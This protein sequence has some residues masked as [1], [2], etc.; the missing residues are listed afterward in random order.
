MP[1]AKIADPGAA[2]AFGSALAYCCLNVGVR[3][4]ID[5]LSVAGILVVRGL[6]GVIVTVMAARAFKKR[7]FGGNKKLLLLIGL[8]GSLSTICT[9]TAIAR[10]PLYQ[11]LVLL[12]LYPALSVVFAYFINSSSISLRDGALAALAFCGC[13]VLIWPDSSAGLALDPGHFIGLGGAALYGLGFVLASR[14]GDEN[15]GLEPVFYYSLWSLI[16]LFAAIAALDLPTGLGGARPVGAAVGLAVIALTAMLMGYAALRWLAPYK[17]GVIGTLEV[18]GGA[19]SS[20]LIFHDP[21]TFRALI[22]GMII[23]TAALKLRQGPA[24]AK[25]GS[26]AED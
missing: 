24:A 6:V 14:L 4:M 18:F 26:E 22:G 17:V 20:W 25:G 13:L 9:T 5:E 19:L 12:Y 7:L 1:N 10:I 23:L 11:A 8:C 15:C 21:I 16:G 3:F 2:L